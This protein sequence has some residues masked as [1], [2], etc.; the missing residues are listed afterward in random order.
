LFNVVRKA[1]RR[2]KEEWL[3]RQCQDIEK[4]TADNRSIESYKLIKQINRLWKPRQSATKD[5]NGKMLQSKEEIKER[6]TDY[7]SGLYNDSENSDTVI[8]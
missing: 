6:W 7:C 4:H 2:D 1:A 8:T 5:N 3:Q